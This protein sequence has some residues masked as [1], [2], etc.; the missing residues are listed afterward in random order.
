LLRPFYN[1]RLQTFG[2][3][4]SFFGQVCEVSPTLPQM[5]CIGLGCVFC[6]GCTIH[7]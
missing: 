2:E 1:P 3:F 4:V 6:P 5:T 7:A